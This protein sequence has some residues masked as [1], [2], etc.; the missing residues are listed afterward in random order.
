MATSYLVS[1]REAKRLIESRV[2]LALLDLYLRS[3]H[4]SH[5]IHRFLYPWSPRL[6][7]A[8]LAR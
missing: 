2:R 6:G 4:F 1:K 8:A 5:H 7:P 3:I